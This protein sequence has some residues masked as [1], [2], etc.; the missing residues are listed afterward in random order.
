MEKVLDRA[1]S[2][3]AA[4]SIVQFVLLTLIEV[5][6]F[7]IILLR[8]M[9]KKDEEIK[10]WNVL[11]KV[12][13]IIYINVILQ[14]TLLGRKDGSR[15]GVEMVPFHYFQSSSSGYRSLAT[16]YSL[17]NC[18]LFVPYGFLISWLPWLKKQRK[19]VN[20]ALTAL[21]SLGTSLLIEL[22]QLISGRGYYETEDLICNTFG[23]AV[24]AVLFCVVFA[25][26]K[27]KR[28]HPDIL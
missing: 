13:L 7:T 20:C 23:G 19:G 22:V 10:L 26:G 25:V 15:I 2:Q 8:L 11:P 18:L 9:Q 14:L 24:G 28:A 16:T 21:I 17:L 4:I 6:V 12:C 1:L 5:A 27:K 3:F